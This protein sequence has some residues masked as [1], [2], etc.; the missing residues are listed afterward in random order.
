MERREEEHKE[1]R[2]ELENS[3]SKEVRFNEQYEPHPRMK[4]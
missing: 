1:G 3:N 2:R 4:M